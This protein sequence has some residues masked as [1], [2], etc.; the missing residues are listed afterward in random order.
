[1]RIK[2]KEEKLD[3]VE[4]KTFFQDRSIKYAKDNPYSVTMFQDG[5]AELVKQRNQKEVEK[6]YSVL[7]IDKYAKILDL[8]CG[9]G[10]WSDAIVDE[11]EEYCGVDFA[12]NLIEIANKRNKRKGRTFL[13]G[14]VTEIERVLSENHKGLFNR[15]L[16]AGV[17][18]YINDDDIENI[19]RQIVPRCEEHSIIYIREPVTIDERLT[20]KNFYSDELKDNYNAIYRTKGELLKVFENT[21]YSAGFQITQSGF[22]FEDDA[23]SNRKE[24]AQYY[25]I[26]ER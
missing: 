20:L 23:L 1:M 2:G 15:I 4:I 12:E 25:F 26:L 9:I 19:F 21:L 13:T 16:M 5:N 14:S 11:I 6:I 8:A 10:R 17:L 24:T 7:K 22:L 18:L 3:Y